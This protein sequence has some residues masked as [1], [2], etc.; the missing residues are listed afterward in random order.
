MLFSGGG[1]GGIRV[2]GSLVAALSPTSPPLMALVRLSRA[3]DSALRFF[4]TFS[5]STIAL[6]FRNSSLFA[7]WMGLMER[8]KASAITDLGRLGD[9]SLGSLPDRLVADT[10]MVN[11]LSSLQMIERVPA[12]TDVQGE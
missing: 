2:S 8:S 5:S 12:R 4:S 9:L 6:R 7:G 10:A 3:L 1:G 11:G